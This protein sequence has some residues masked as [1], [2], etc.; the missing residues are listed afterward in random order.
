MLNME[1]T[2][3]RHNGAYYLVTTS[4]SYSLVRLEGQ[5]RNF[6]SVLAGAKARS[7]LAHTELGSS[8]GRCWALLPLGASGATLII[9]LCAHSPRLFRRE[10]SAVTSQTNSVLRLRSY[11][12]SNSGH[13]A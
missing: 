11:V 3:D 12:K 8:I 1:P 5:I 10:R 6:R 9:I 2:V 7:A 13:D 4:H